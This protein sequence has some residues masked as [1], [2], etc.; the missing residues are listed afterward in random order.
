MLTVEDPKVY[1][2]HVPNNSSDAH[3]VLRQYPIDRQSSI[4]VKNTQC[5][6][7]IFPFI[8]WGDETDEG[9]S[10]GEDY[11]YDSDEA[12]ERDEDRHEIRDDVKDIV[13]TMRK[14]KILLDTNKIK[15]RGLNVEQNLL[16]AALFKKVMMI[17][18]TC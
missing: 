2:C 4:C 3:I 15:A 17:G 10:E 11:D 16:R 5:S 18:R 7:Q 14:N 6:L 9:S 8:E 1:T 13:K 12:Y